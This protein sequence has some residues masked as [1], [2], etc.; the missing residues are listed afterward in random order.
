METTRQLY[1]LLCDNTLGGIMYDLIC[2]LEET[3][4][5][6]GLYQN[7]G[8]AEELSNLI[9]YVVKWNRLSSM[10]VITQKSRKVID[11]WQR[12]TNM[13]KLIEKI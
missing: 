12:Q 2:D 9:N 8:T 11:D 4:D 6:K 13:V 3:K 7:H 10:V 1:H 5:A